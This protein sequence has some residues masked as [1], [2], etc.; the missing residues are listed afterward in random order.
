VLELVDELGLD[1]LTDCRVDV[2]G[3]VAGALLV[4]H[5]DP[6]RSRLRQRPGASRSTT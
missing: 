3:L 6:G 4:L 1:H 5:D 2:A